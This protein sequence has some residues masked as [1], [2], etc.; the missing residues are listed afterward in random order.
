VTVQNLVREAQAAMLRAFDRADTVTAAQ[1][2]AAM[3]GFSEKTASRG[4]A[5]LTRRRRCDRL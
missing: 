5:E 4:R 3:A 2:H 1:L